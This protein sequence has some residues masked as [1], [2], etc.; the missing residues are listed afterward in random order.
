MLYALPT[1][2]PINWSSNQRKSIVDHP[3]MLVSGV[4][5]TASASTLADQVRQRYLQFLWLPDVS[6]ILLHLVSLIEGGLS[7]S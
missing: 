3:N 2:G 5:Q 6:T 7:E 4:F 1:T